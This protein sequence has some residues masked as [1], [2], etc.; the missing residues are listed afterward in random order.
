M[1]K[2]WLSHAGVRRPIADCIYVRYYGHSTNMLKAG[3]SRLL[4]AAEGYSFFEKSWAMVIGLGQWFSRSFG[5]DPHVYRKTGSGSPKRRKVLSKFNNLWS[6]AIFQTANGGK[7][8]AFYFIIMN[9]HK[10]RIWK[11]YMCSRAHSLFTKL[12]GSLK[13]SLWLTTAPWPTIWKPVF[14]ANQTLGCLSLLLAVTVLC[15]FNLGKIFVL[16]FRLSP[17]YFAGILL[18]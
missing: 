2:V 5:S 18:G 1:L 17:F 8:A 9:A 12:C 6:W 13:M 15:D 7:M 16:Y 14:Y 10:T 4:W 11:D 3:S